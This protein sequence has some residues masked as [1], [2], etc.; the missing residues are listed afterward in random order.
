AVRER[1][2]QNRID[3]TVHIP[4]RA[5]VKIESESGMV[6]V[7]GDFEM[8]DVFTNTGTI[9]ADVPLDNVKFNFLWESSR[10]RFLSDVEL[11]RVKERA[12]GKYTISGKLGT[13]AGKSKKETQSDRDNQEEADRSDKE[14]DKNE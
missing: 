4:K 6:D 11:P 14:S 9:H 7:I 2:A 3:L 13:G 5:R 1:T 8:A 10:P 12:G